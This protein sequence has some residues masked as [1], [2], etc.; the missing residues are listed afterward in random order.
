[1]R[2]LRGHVKTKTALTA[3]RAAGVELIVAIKRFFEIVSVKEVAQLIAI[4]FAHFA[5]LNELEHNAAEI[6][7]RLH[8]PAMKHSRRHKAELFERE[9]TKSRKQLLPRDVR[10]FLIGFAGRTTPQMLLRVP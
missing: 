10:I 6:F 3:E 7:G 8:A 1:M 4:G 2:D 5:S 9:L